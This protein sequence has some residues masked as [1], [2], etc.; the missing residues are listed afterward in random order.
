MAHES[1]GTTLHQATAT[2]PGS[3][4]ATSIRIGRHDLLSD[5]GADM[6]GNATAPSP[7]DLLTAALASC[8]T[9]TVRSYAQRKGIALVSVS[10]Y[11]QHLAASDGHPERFEVSLTLQGEFDDAQ[12]ERMIAIAGKCPVH[13]LLAAA[14]PVE[15]VLSGAS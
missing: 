2:T 11:A 8:T 1:S 3:T 14:T 6:G 12:R 15:V 4:Y 13:R 9:M 5:A 10:A 7:V